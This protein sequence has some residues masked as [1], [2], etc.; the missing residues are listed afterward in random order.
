MNVQDYL[1]QG[2]LLDQR[3]NYDLQRL[4]E[5]KTDISGIY[6]TGITA[7]KVQNSKDGDAPY[8][9]ALLRIE[10]LQEQINQEIDMLVNLKTQID[11]TIRQ[12]ENAEEQMI[13]KYRYLK[14]MTWDEIGGMLKIGKSTAKRWHE[15]AL[16]KLKMPEKPIITYLSKDFLK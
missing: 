6:S 3:I 1:R 12:L 11:Q 10:E 2:R 14:G 8:V 13:L 15:Q 9:K 4:E 7:S 16:A 5:M